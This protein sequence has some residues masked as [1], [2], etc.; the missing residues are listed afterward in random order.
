MNTTNPITE[1]ITAAL[2]TATVIN[3][4]LAI[5]E[6]QIRKA[7]LSGASFSGLTVVRTP[8]KTVGTNGANATD[9]TARLRKVILAMN[10]EWSHEDVMAKATWAEP[11]F[12]TNVL[13]HMSKEGV[14]ARVKRGVYR[15]K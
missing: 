4:D 6:L 2:N 12:A 15:T 11:R 3:I 5:E 10:G 13:F 1:S 8:R 9:K 14:I 7:E